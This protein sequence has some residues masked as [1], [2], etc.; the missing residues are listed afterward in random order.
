M[1]NEEL[2]DASRELLREDE[3]RDR[4]GQGAA[5]PLRRRP[6]AERRR[7]CGTWPARARASAATWRSTST[8]A[9]RRWPT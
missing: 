7:R 6:A 2:L 3:L 9:R 8:A 5:R 4:A 1:A